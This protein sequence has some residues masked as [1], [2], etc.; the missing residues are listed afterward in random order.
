MSAARCCGVAPEA[1]AAAM[2]AVVE[3]TMADRRAG[4]GVREV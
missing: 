2:A 1:T 4:M 3:A